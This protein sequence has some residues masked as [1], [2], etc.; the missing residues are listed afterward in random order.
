ML[1]TVGRHGRG[2]IFQLVIETTALG[3]FWLAMLIVDWH[4]FVFYYLTSYYLGWVLSYAE[5]YLEHYGCEPGNQYANSVSSY[6]GVYNLFWFNN[7]YHQEHH[8]DPKVHWTQMRR[9]R[10]EIKDQLAANGTRI[11]RGP[12][13][14]AFFEDWL[15][16][17]SPPP[18]AGAPPASNEASEM[19][20][21]AA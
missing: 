20:K 15:A 8:W 4:Y 18:K 7:G 6:N 10:D 5:G 2:H 14:T 21:L 11:L 13:I 16:G 19:R 9:L 3:A 12:H 1:R 17:K